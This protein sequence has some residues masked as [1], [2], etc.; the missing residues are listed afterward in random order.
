MSTETTTRFKCD[1][2]KKRIKGPQSLYIRTVKST[3][4][5]WDNLNVHIIHRSG[6]NNDATERPA[7]LCRRCAVALLRDAARRC[8]AGERRT[9]GTTTIEM[10]TWD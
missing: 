4:A 3:G 7:E 9:K 2:C 10:E 8:G 6:Y 1:Y 5:Y